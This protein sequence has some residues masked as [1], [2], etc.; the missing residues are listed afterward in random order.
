VTALRVVALR[1]WWIGL[2]RGLLALAL[3][4]ILLARPLDAAWAVAGVAV[5][6]LADGALVTWAAVVARR[7]GLG[8]WLLLGRG[9]AGVLVGLVLAALPVQ[10]LVPG[11]RPFAVVSFIVVLPIVLLL[12]AVHTVWAV[13]M[14]IAVWVRLR[15]EFPGDWSGLVAAGWVAVTGIA[16]WLM[17]LQLASAR[18]FGLLAAV[19]GAVLVYHALQRRAAGT[20]PAPITS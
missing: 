9:V 18:A 14:E 7:H 13:T 19:A 10:A 20:S 12:A 5:Y 11:A 15:G 17:A 4:A 16:V 3:G 2:A 8:G 6:W 1:L